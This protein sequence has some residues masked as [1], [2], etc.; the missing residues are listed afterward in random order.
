MSS[1]GA[2][3]RRS[4]KTS[5]I[6]LLA[7]M[8]WAFRLTWSIS[9]L[10]VSGV[11]ISTCGRAL[12][13]AGLALTARG[14]I[15]GLVD[16]TH[17]GSDDFSAL[18]PWLLMGAGLAIVQAISDV[19]SR[20]L[21]QR[22][23]DEI[24]LTITADILKHAAGL[25]IACFEDHRFHDVMERARQDTA[26][27]FSQ[28]LINVI[29]VINNGLQLVSLLLILVVIEPF[30]T[31]VL[32]PVALPYLL[33]Q[34]R[35]AGVRHVKEQT[36][37]TGR[38][39]THYFVR[40]LTDPQSAAEVKLLDLAP[41]LINRYRTLITEFRDQDRQLHFR[42][43]VGGSAF[44]LSAAVVFY[45]ILSWVVY[46]ALQSGLTVGDVAIY[47]GA[48]SAL[49]SN[50]SNVIQSM[51]NTVEHALFV[52]NL[53]EFLAIQPRIHDTGS[54]IPVS[55]QG[56]IELT[57]V[58]FSYPGSSQLILSDI[59]LHIEPGETVALVGENGAGK[60][61][62]A[63]LIARLY[64]PDQ[65]YIALD[66]V[67]I[68][69][70]PVAYLHS[71]LAF[72]L[73]GFGRYEAT[74]ADNIAYGDWRRLLHDQDQV[75]AI[76]KEANIQ[77]MIER[78]PQTYGTMLGKMFGGHDL[79]T[80]QWQQLA[81]A[82]AFAR[83]ACVLILDEPTASLDARA[84][85]AIFSRFRELLKGRTT[86]LISHRFSTVSMADRIL[87]LDQGRLIEQGTHQEL[88]AHNGHYATL[89]NLQ[90][91]QMPVNGAA[92]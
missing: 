27:H 36:R 24:R 14:L 42:S 28:F 63:K 69:Q 37:T 57:H 55:R 78:M 59:S 4:L 20:Y 54:T 45:L 91:R 84:E 72:V 52:S 40:L 47:A 71:Q 21:I 65:G 90:E 61:T 88:M 44:A 22:L 3:S 34:L 41:L 8:Q 11:V 76:A 53:K 6:A 74:A 49:R 43:F 87:V 46:R 15:N 81:V 17:R 68:R 31:A 77:E 82:R 10:L 64:E 19:G 30:I 67:D 92:S 60:T 35:L 23:T 56:E 1:D 25:D 16:L 58:S 85:H 13:P 48:S 2:S 80:G 18:I 50:L 73:Q 83:D 66:G 5:V 70:L 7:N 39:W 29:G 9:P 89:Y 51:S 33:F 12:V 79:S 26:Q 32:A 62:L 86:I 38:R 75:K